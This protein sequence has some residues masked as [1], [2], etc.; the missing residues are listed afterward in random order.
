MPK[1][2]EC[3][4][5]Q[6]IN[7]GYNTV[8][9]PHRLSLSLVVP[10]ESYAGRPVPTMMDHIERVQLVE[11]LGFSAVWLRDVPFNVPSFGDAG[12]TYDPYRL[13]SY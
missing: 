7:R 1:T 11:S 4:Q 9:R 10:I 6:S 12:Q 3:K 13:N 8:F 2:V 5:F